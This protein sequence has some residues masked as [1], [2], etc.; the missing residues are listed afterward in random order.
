M[1]LQRYDGFDQYG[2]DGA[3]LAASA[4]YSSDVATPLV[5][6]TGG[7][8]NRG[9]ARRANNDTAGT[10]LRYT[11]ASPITNGNTLIVS[12]LID[13]NPST[14][15][16]AINALFY[17]RTGGTVNAYL[18]VDYASKELRWY[19]G[20]ATLRATSAPAVFPASGFTNVELKVVRQTAATGSLEVRVDGITV[21]TAASII[22]AASGTQWDSI[23][24]GAGANVSGATDINGRWWYSQIIVGDATGSA[25]FND[26]LGPVIVKTKTVTGD[27]ADQDWGFTGGATAWES[28]DDL[29][30]D[31]GTTYISSALASDLSTF[32]LADLDAGDT[33]LAVMVC[34][35]STKTDAGAATYRVG[36]LSDASF[37]WSPSIAPTTAYL[38]AGYHI[39]PTDPDGGGAWT[40]AQYNASL[41]AV[42]RL[43]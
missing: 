41:L 12:A 3:R 22:T 40:E 29:N 30:P 39:L 34:A 11:L 27:G 7:F 1:A 36:I 10:G 23:T 28:I 21:F 6:A 25:P 37:G 24:F 19:T 18:A 35:R 4:G 13:V 31:D 42:E 8:N 20:T 33:L 15:T 9:R 43:T 16:T 2:T 5:E 38:T 26:F 17:I 32:A 14:P